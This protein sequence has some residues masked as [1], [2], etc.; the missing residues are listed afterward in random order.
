MSTDK[1]L[2]EIHSAQLG[3]EAFRAEVIAKIEQPVVESFDIAALQID[4]SSEVDCD[5]Y[6]STGQFLVDAMQVKSPS[7]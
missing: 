1:A 2:P 7:A 5:P 3:E 6:N 4:K